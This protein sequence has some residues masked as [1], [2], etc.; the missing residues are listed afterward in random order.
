MTT[1]A[2]G[3]FDVQLNPRPPDTEAD[4]AVGQLS[5]DKQFHGDLEAT[6]RGQ[7]RRKAALKVLPVT[8]QWNGSTGCCMGAAAHSFSCMQAS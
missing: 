6:S 7:M 4:A 8:S 5:I 3:S 2:S 1:H